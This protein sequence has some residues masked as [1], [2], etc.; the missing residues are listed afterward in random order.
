MGALDLAK[1]VTKG[2]LA[3]AKKTGP[4]FS[5][6]DIVL[7]E[8]QRG[9]GTGNEFLTE[10]IKKG[11]KPTELRERG[12]EQKLKAMPKVSKAE[13]KKVFEENPAPKVEEKVFT[14]KSPDYDE[15]LEQKALELYGEDYWKLARDERQRID[16]MYDQI[17]VTKYEQY[18]TPGGENYREILLKLP[19]VKGQTPFASSHWVGEPNVLAHIRV[20]DFQMPQSGYMVVNTR[21]G[22][23]SQVFGTAEEAQQYLSTLPASLQPSLKIQQGAGQPKKV[24]LVDEIQSDWH[25]AGRKHGYANET[26][27]QRTRKQ[28]DEVAKAAGFDNAFHA[29]EGWKLHGIPAAKEASDLYDA[30][31]KFKSVNSVP[32]APFKKNWHELAMKRV[33]DYAAEN[34]YDTVA[35]T[36]GAEQA[37]RYDLSKHVDTITYH[38]ESQT[39]KAFDKDLNKVIDKTE[40]GRAHV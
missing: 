32:D 23:K 33:L 20:Q 11:A 31:I 27:Y 28:A 38:P 39:L 25:Q 14:D 34:G 9:K 22:N 1:G 8:L 36:P 21:S 24:L 18:K 26:E 13:V 7:D 15:F 30:A 29:A 6:A 37:K 4:F 17:P 10:M 19:E 5:K 16:K 35:I 3:T 40:I 12:I 2:A